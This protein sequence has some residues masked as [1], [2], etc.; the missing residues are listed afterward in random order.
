MADRYNLQSQLEH[1]QQRHLG[2]GHADT[3]KYEWAV[4]QHRDSL[5][6][7]VT[8]PAMLDYLAIA[9]GVTRQ[10]VRYSMLMKMVKPVGDNPNKQPA[11]K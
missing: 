10:R 1:L 11:N 5:C 8:H 2:T 9:Q 6:Y 3:T 4:N 7:Y